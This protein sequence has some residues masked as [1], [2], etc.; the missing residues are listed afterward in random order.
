MERFRKERQQR[1]KAAKRKGWVADIL[2]GHCCNYET[3]LGF[4]RHVNR[5]RSR[6][7]FCTSLEGTQNDVMH[8]DQEQE[9][10]LD[11]L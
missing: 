6:H 8:E 2:K 10:F 7:N 5:Y 4:S 1:L 9:S 3:N 11:A